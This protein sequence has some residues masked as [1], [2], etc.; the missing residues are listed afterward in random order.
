MARGGYRENAGAKPKHGEKS[1]IRY[2]P[3]SVPNTATK[4]ELE[5]FGYSLAGDQSA[6]EQLKTIIEGKFQSN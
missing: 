5:L 3:G 1:K 4:R 2:V 6:W